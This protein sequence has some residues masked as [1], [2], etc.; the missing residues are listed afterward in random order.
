MDFDQ[1]EVLCE[2][3]LDLLVEFITQLEPL[4]QIQITRAPKLCLTMIQ[5]EDSVEQQ[6]F[7]LG[8]ALTTSC[9][10]FI[11]GHT[12]YGIV[13]EDQPQRAYCIAVIDALSRQKDEYWPKVWA[14]LSQLADIIKAEALEEQHRVLKTMVDF[15]LMEDA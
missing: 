6:P 2:C 11:N 10:V 7:Y 1:D 13:L 9:E 4:Y 3:P 8:E 5:A 14:F 12:G 15:K